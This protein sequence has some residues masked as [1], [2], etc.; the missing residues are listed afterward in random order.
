[1]IWNLEKFVVLFA[2]NS[3]RM[4]VLFDISSEKLLS[5]NINIDMSYG[6][7]CSIVCQYLFE[8]GSIVLCKLWESV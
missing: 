7:V 4:A 1:M 8:N 2:S 6:K 3:L 5:E